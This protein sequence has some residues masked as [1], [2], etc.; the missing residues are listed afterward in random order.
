[1]RLNSKELVYIAQNC[2]TCDK[3]GLLLFKE[4]Q[5]GL[6]KRGETYL[7]R[8]F[9]LKGNLLF[10]FKNKESVTK[11]EPIG[12]MV[13]E[14]CTVEL[15]SEEE[16][17]N[18]FVLVCEGEN[19]VFKFAAMSEEDRDHWIQALHIASY[20]CLK[21]QLESL[22]D[23]LQGKTG[24]NPFPQQAQQHTGIDLD[25]HTEDQVNEDCILE[26][27]LSCL[28]LKCDSSG[29]PPNPLIVIHTLEPP[30][31]LLW[32]HHNHTEIVEKTCN[33]Q[34]LKT[35]GFGDGENVNLIT[36]VKVTIY[37][38]VERMTGTMV[39]LGHSIFTLRD[40]IAAEDNTLHLSIK[41]PDLHDC[42]KLCV[43]GWTNS[44]LP[45]S[46]VFQTDKEDEYIEQEVKSKSINKQEYSPKNLYENVICKSFRFSTNS[47]KEVLQVYEYMAES[48]W[49]Y[50]IPHKL[51][52]LF[53]EEEKR[54]VSLLQE[55]G[56]LVPDIES[57]QVAWITLSAAI[58]ETFINALDTLSIYKGAY[59][60]A[61]RDKDN[62][63]YQFVP[64]NI[65]LQR[66]AVGTEGSKQGTIYE[67]VTMGAFTDH[68]QKWKNGGLKR[69]LQSQ[70]D[71]Y[72]P[73]STLGQK[74]KLHKA[75]KLLSDL[76]ELKYVINLGCEK[77]CQT[78]INE[79]MEEV[80]ARIDFIANKS[81]KLV[82]LCDEPLLQ[83]SSTEYSHAKTS[84]SHVD[85]KDLA[86]SLTHVKDKKEKSEPADNGDGSSSR[87]SLWSG[88]SLAKSPTLEPWEV[89][90]L[91]LEAAVVCLISKVEEMLKCKN[92]KETT[93]WLSDISP[94]IIKLQSFVEIVFQ[95]ANLFLTF[96][97]LRENRF[98]IKTMHSIKYRRDVMTTHSISTLFTGIISKVYNYKDNVDYFTRISK[99]GLLAKFEGLLS[100]YGDEMGM[101][102]DMCVAVDDLS[103]V[104]FSFTLSRDGTTTTTPSLQRC[105]KNGRFPDINRHCIHMT[106]GVSSDLYDK[107]PSNLQK[108]DDIKV[109]P[110]LFNIGINEQATLAERFGST[111]LQDQINTESVAILSH[112]YED[113]M[114]H[115]AD[116]GEKSTQAYI[117]RLIQQLNTTIISK[118]SK[119]VEILHIAEELC[120][121]LDG[122]HFVS[123]KSGKD[124]TSM[125]VT[126]QQVQILQQ[127]HD[128]A[129][130]VF[131]QALDCFR[132]VGCRRENTLKNAGMKKYAFN[133]LQLLSFPKL[134]RPPGGTYGNVQT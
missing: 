120:R 82:E 126:L 37:H 115:F 48:R 28:D 36:R 104:T 27:S 78:L 50:D 97:S 12:L 108:G 73:Q 32:S 54:K 25:S 60:K 35:I 18:A 41:S 134:Y 22:T 29:Q 68:V 5:D 81:R 109:I 51:L 64:V 117:G 13:L 39:Q 52:C 118:K 31:Q 79:Y 102:E 1:M 94:A 83:T 96:L 33:P 26:I 49:S 113:Y 100:C 8:Y 106:L 129:S 24:K 80:Q 10:Y 76:A 3:E 74:T 105:L 69:L 84:A 34:F 87:S 19:H 122:V 128:L 133:S 123:C 98:N 127:E 15:E 30:D 16:I 107:L 116:P 75:C 59:F 119:N 63:E 53:V 89:T 58:V 57:D 72:T 101:L 2:V 14:R 43:I 92:N 121:K 85:G 110:V 38:V 23:Q 61:S 124:R 40:I 99:I 77:L 7:E 21:M 125:A 6:L 9:R 112:Y 88:S 67:A 91:N 86:A 11:S 17:P 114:K 131:W 111:N 103:T 130:H 46:P 42:G 45:I 132:S 90:R 55:M 70:V 65:H 47:Q 44:A 62:K 20:E 4:K 56:E 95:R 71:L 66:M 93:S